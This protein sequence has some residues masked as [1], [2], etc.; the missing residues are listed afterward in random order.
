[1][2]CWNGLCLV[3][4]GEVDSAIWQ[5]GCGPLMESDAPFYLI[6]NVM[7]RQKYR[8]HEMLRPANG[9]RCTILFNNQCDDEAKV[10]E[11]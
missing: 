6:T 11:A 4:I 8:K 10:Q 7:T 9:K 5:I 2:G 3:A 1:M